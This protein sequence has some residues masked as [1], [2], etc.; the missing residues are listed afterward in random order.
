MK[1]NKCIRC[2]KIERFWRV[3]ERVDY[4]GTAFHFCVECA[5]IL[6]RA[7]YERKVTNIDQANALYD[8]FKEGITN[9]G[10]KVTLL[11][12]LLLRRT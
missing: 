9:Q 3:F 1:K 4:D 10:N 12:W 11:N 6:Y 7:D 8:E 2:D 5:Q